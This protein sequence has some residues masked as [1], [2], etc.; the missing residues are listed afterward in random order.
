MRELITPRQPDSHK[1]DYGR[2]LIVAGSMGKTGAAHLSAT[3]ALRSGAGL[4]TVVTPAACQP[5]LAA[6]GAEYMTE[7]LHET[8][9]GLHPDGV[10]HVI[11]MARDVLALGL[12]QQGEAVPGDVDQE[13]LDWMIDQVVA[14]RS[15]DPND[16]DLSDLEPLARASGNARVVQLGEQSHGD[17]ATFTMKCR[18]IRFLHER[19][20]FDVLAFESGLVALQQSLQLGARRSLTFRAGKLFFQIALE[21]AGR[22]GDVERGVW[23]H[24]ERV[25]A[26][27]E[28]NGHDSGQDRLGQNVAVDGQHESARSDDDYRHN[29]HQ[30]PAIA[31][32]V[33][34]S[35]DGCG[36]GSPA[37]VHHWTGG[38][39]H[40]RK[41]QSGA[42][43][44][45]Q[46]TD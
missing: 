16:A 26:N 25:Y 23:L 24:V 42:T 10:D 29:E 44:R 27:G 45:V 37:A 20:G 11:E 13:R 43:V 36:G 41:R 2:V 35:V 18:L 46:S 17:S 30:R 19:L 38:G 22:H 21:L 33:H 7:P 28:R 8:A 5:I 14:L 9:E 6:M 15:A 34:R 39:Q 4:V 31:R 32:P 3:G 1:G 40:P 12:L